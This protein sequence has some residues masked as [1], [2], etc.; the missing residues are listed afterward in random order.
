MHVR[1]IL[2]EK[3][4]S[5]LTIKPNATLQEAARTLHENRIGALVVVGVNEQIKGILSERDLVRTNAALRE[6]RADLQ[7]AMNAAEAE[8]IAREFP[9]VAR[10][11]ELPEATVSRNGGR[12]VLTL[13]ST[14]FAQ[15]SDARTR[16]RVAC[17][18]H[19]ARERRLALDIAEARP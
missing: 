6:A 7:A 16:G 1:A 8:M 17:I 2:D 10:N 18:E 19:W 4:R 9:D 13:P 14:V 15:M 5:V 11:S 12:H 3:G